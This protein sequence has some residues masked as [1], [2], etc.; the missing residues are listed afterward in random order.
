VAQRETQKVDVK[1]LAKIKDEAKRLVLELIF[2]GLGEG[3][4]RTFF[5][6]ILQER[7]E[8]T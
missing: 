3:E 8:R 7:G 5:D 4:I 1:R 2:L 6:E